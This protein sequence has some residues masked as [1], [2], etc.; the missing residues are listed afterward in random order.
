MQTIS[1]AE[2]ALWLTDSAKPAPLLLD[3]REPWEHE[4]CH[5]GG[6]LLIPMHDVP[7]RFNELDADRPIVCVCHHGARSMQVANFLER[8]GFS[9]VI[10]L[11]GGVHA[12]ATQ[13]DPQ[14]PTY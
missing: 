12:W 8:Q 13:V 5:I 2:L 14:M 9:Q 6:V 4:T 3:V 7:A 1:A 11:S 10:N